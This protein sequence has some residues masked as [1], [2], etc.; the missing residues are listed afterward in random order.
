M[1]GNYLEKVHRNEITS[2]SKVKT[3]LVF[4]ILKTFQNEISKRQRFFVFQKQI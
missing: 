1:E 3:A 4:E 2:K